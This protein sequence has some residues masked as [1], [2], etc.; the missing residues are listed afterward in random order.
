VKGKPKLCWNVTVGSDLR[1]F[2]FAPTT[3]DYPSQ[4]AGIL[5]ELSGCLNLACFPCS[6]VEYSSSLVFNQYPATRDVLVCP[7]AFCQDPEGSVFLLGVQ[8]QVQS[9]RDQVL[10]VVRPVGGLALF[11]MNKFRG[12]CC[13]VKAGPNCLVEERF[14]GSNS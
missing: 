8:L 4:R 12:E 2:A 1:V 10:F 9:V 5:R 6:L 14:R 11:D 13:V 7:F 3:P